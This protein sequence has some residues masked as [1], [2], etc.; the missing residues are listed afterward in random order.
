[1]L[2]SNALVFLFYRCCLE[3]EEQRKRRDFVP[4]V[5]KNGIRSVAAGG[6]CVW[7]GCF[8]SCCCRWAE[9]EYCEFSIFLFFFYI[10]FLFCVVLSLN[11]CCWFAWVLWDVVAFWVLHVTKP[12]ISYWFLFKQLFWKELNLMETFIT[13]K[14]QDSNII[15]SSEIPFFLTNQSSFIN[16]ACR[17]NLTK[18]AILHTHN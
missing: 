5:L 13:S 2:F 1:M 10:F 15:A 4:W 8:C 18:Q 7:F 3:R 17:K 9:E 11:L 14:L 6:V 16:Y 12:L